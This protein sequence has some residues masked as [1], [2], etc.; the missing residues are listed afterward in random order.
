MPGGIL[1]DVRL[2]LIEEGV[3]NV[4]PISP[5][6]RSQAREEVMT[7]QS[8]MAMA[9]ETVGPEQA[10]MLIDMPGSMRN[11]KDKLKDQIVS[12]RTEEQILAIM[13]SMGGPA[14]EQ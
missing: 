13:Q 1:Q 7:A 4:R 5:L 6:E 9:M 11:V 2:P 8:I 10:N 12:F 14:G 3:V